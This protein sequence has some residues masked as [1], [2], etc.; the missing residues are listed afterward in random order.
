MRKL[1]SAECKGEQW[2]LSSTL[3]TALAATATAAATARVTVTVTESAVYAHAG[4]LHWKRREEKKE[5]GE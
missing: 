4:L 5:R 1:K 3:A 2:W